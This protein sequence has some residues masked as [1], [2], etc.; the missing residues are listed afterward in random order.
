M[1]DPKQGYNHAK[2]KDLHKIVSSK[3]PTLK[4][5]SNNNNNNE[6]FMKREPLTYTT[7]RRAVQGNEK[8]AFTQ[9]NASTKT[10]QHVLLMLSC[11]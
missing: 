6:I 1:L 8:I 7:A 11:V 4:F 10:T 2:L 3:K 9:D 5:L